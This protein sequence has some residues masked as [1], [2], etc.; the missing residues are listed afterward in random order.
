MFASSADPLS[1]H[2]HFAVSQ[3][4]GSQPVHVGGINA[5]GAFGSDTGANW[6][7]RDFQGIA[8]GPCGAPVLAWADDNGV[9]ATE[10]ASPAMVD[11][12]P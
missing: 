12:S 11:C 2:P 7:L 3:V 6:G 9:K 4:S 1:S 10:T 8:V 5:A